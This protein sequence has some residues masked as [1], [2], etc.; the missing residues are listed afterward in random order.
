MD[1]VRCIY[2]FIHNDLECAWIPVCYC[3]DGPIVDNLKLF[4]R[5]YGAKNLSIDLIHVSKIE[6]NDSFYSDFFED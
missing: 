3:D 2:A 4:K 6:E 5:L 1:F